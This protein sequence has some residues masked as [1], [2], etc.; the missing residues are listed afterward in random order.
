MSDLRSSGLQPQRSGGPKK[1]FPLAKKAKRKLTV[2]KASRRPFP[3]QRVA[4]LWSKGRTIAEI[5]AAVGRV[6]EGK[7]PFHA[8]RVHLTRM[9]KGY[10]DA[11]GKL[12]KLPHRI[13]RKTLRLAKLAG[14]KHRRNQTRRA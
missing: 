8:L 4:R 1:P 5:A 14:T 2:P 3:Y 6:G 13:S 12:V 10:K 11:D 9:H 7:D